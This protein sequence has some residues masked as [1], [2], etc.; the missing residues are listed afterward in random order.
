MLRDVSSSRATGH[1]VPRTFVAVGARSTL[2]LRFRVIMDPDHPDP[3]A[4]P[5]AYPTLRGRQTAA[6]S[7]VVSRSSRMA[8]VVRDGNGYLV[9]VPVRLSTRPRGH[10][11]P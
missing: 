2:V 4:L 1:E 5:L 6:G 11:F 8:L 9:V 10:P 7:I 3:C